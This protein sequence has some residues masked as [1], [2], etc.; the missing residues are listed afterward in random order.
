MSKSGG[1]VGKAEESV[2]LD[3]RRDSSAKYLFAGLV[4]VAGLVVLVLFLK[5][6]LIWVQYHEPKPVSVED[7]AR[8]RVPEGG[9]VTVQGIIDPRYSHIVP[10]PGGDGLLEIGLLLADDTPMGQWQEALVRDRDAFRK[11]L[12]PALNDEL[13]HREI[14][15]YFDAVDVFASKFEKHGAQ[16]CRTIKDS[17]PNYAVGF[18][19][20]YAG[21][22]EPGFRNRIHPERCWTLRDRQPAGGLQE[23]PPWPEDITLSN[24]IK[25]SEIPTLRAHLEEEVAYW[26]G[27]APQ[28]VAEIEALDV[29]QAF[30]EVVTITGTVRPLPT[31]AYESFEAVD[32]LLFD[33]YFYVMEGEEPATIGVIM[34]P[35][36]LVLVVAMGGLMGFWALRARSRYDRILQEE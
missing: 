15:A 1:T 30:G 2:P 18:A 34:V 19:R 20:P 13:T 26:E 4:L 16:L 8:T 29:E 23:R 25:P 12:D 22:E 17:W 3:Q 14:K 7:V 33:I 21:S 31:D 27:T 11:T 10:A 24:P 28:V 35:A 32:D 5:P 9:Q 6:F 36:G